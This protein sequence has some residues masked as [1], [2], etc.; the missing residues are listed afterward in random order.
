M[1]T[2]DMAAPAHRSASNRLAR[3]WSEAADGVRVVVGML[4][5]MWVAWVVN[6]LDHYRL[7]QYGIL[8]R[9]VGHLYGIV[10]SPFLHASFSHILGNS[11]PFLILGLV[12]AGSGVARLIAVTV[13]S[14]VIG[15]A[16]VWLTAGAGTETIGA[17]GLVFGFAAYLVARGIFSH[18]I[19]ELLVGGVVGA[20]FGLSLLSD[21][22]P[23][24]GVSW[25]GHLFGALAGVIAAAL[26][27][28]RAE[29]RS[30]AATT[31]VTTA[32]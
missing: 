9:N 15:G 30:G 28:T 7:D 22:I 26:L 25:Q 2:P 16:G 8:P 6:A 13:I 27:T 5:I 20:V 4:A 31:S 23:R 10:T 17:S 21:L 1:Q 19:G 3:Q 11:I 18:R 24:S 32:R 29:R 12:V 14:I